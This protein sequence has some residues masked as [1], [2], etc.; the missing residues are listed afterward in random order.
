MYQ[1]NK[2][3]HKINLCRT[4]AVIQIYFLKKVPAIVFYNNVQM[5]FC[6]VIYFTFYGVVT[7]VGGCLE[8]EL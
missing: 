7:D 5:L 4:K 1:Q 6:F 3:L 2:S 8:T